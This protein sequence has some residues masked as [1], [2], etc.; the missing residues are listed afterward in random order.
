MYESGQLWPVLHS[1]KKD[2]HRVPSLINLGLERDEGTS[3]ACQIRLNFVSLCLR[4]VHVQQRVVHAG[5][6]WVGDSSMHKLHM[7]TKG[8]RGPEWVKTQVGSGVRE[9]AEHGA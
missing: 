5:V 3:P 9:E 2:L 4:V 8:R 1:S 6:S 7:Q